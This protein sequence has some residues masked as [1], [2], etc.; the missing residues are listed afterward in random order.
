MNDDLT[1]KLILITNFDPFD[2]KHA[3][4]GSR[5]ASQM[6][7]IVI[8]EG[9]CVKHRD[10]PENIEVIE[11]KRTSDAVAGF[12]GGVMTAIFLMSIGA[13]LFALIT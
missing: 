10:G 11:M 8:A 13:L 6:A 7:D 1:K 9:K 12:V 4:P 5:T 2:L 3:P